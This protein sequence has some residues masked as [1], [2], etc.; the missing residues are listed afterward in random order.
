MKSF[1][2]FFLLLPGFFFPV[3]AQ[4]KVLRAGPMVGYSTMREVML[5]V[6]TTSPAQVKFGYYPEGKATEKKFSEIAHTTSDNYG[7]AKVV[8]P[9][10]PGQRYVYE[11]Y[12]NEKKIDLPYPTRFESQALWQWRTD[13]PEFTFALG[14]CAYVNQTEYDRPGKPYGGDYEIFET[15]RKQNPAFMLW[16]GDNTYLRE[17]DWDTRS[18]IYERYSHTRALPEMQALL[19]GTHHY[20]TWDDH[21]FGPD[22]SDRSFWMK[23]T[24][25]AAF[26]DFWANPHFGVAG[27][28]SGTFFWND[29]QFF[30]LDNRY[31]RAPDFDPDPSRPLLGEAQLNWL[32]D[33]LTY[34]R[35]PFKFVVMG[36]QLLNPHDAPWAEGYVKY[37]QEYQKLLEGL[38]SR[39]ISGV[40]FLDGDRHH[41]ELSKMERE[42]TYPLY[43]LTVSPLT[44]G[45][46]G[47][48]SKDEPNTYRMSGTLYGQR[49]FGLIRVSGPRQARVLQIRILN[50]EGQEIWQ[51]EIKAEELK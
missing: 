19:A 21:D 24:T 40:I 49:N 15:I 20:A 47:D 45:A 14:S 8:L 46:V 28:I 39:K 18:G 43:D 11:L 48:R 6:Q 44:A 51:H 12:L 26:K 4:N 50:K 22:N 27:G 33:A 34:S 29:C 37:P 10:E 13:P 2:L 9:T 25:L 42:G 36:G 41:T 31:F 38:K 35:A 16:M 32:L 30:L 23:E 17:V 5:W 1:Y 3:E 7:I